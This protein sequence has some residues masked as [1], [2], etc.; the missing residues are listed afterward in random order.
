MKILKVLP[1]SDIC[2]SRLIGA[3]IFECQVRKPNPK[4][5]S[6]SLSM[7]NGYVCKHPSRI[8]FIRQKA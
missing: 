1:D 2:R 5:C 6:Y 4:Y 7:G 8:E 3:D